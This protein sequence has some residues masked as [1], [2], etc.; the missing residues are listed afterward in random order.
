M[1]EK[2]LFKEWNQIN[3]SPISQINHQ[4]IALS[5]INN[6]DEE[7]NI[8]KWE[9]YISK[10]TKQDNPYYY[11]GKWHLYIEIP[12]NYPMNPPS[13]RFDNQTPI[14]HP[15]I[16]FETGEICLDILKAENWSPA[17]NLQYLIVAILMLI[18]HPEPDSPLNID[19][20]NLYRHDKLA[21]ESI[22]QYNIWQYNTFYHHFKNESGIKS[23][24]EV[25]EEEEED[26]DDISLIKDN[27]NNTIITGGYSDTYTKNTTKIKKKLQE[28]L[29]DPFYNDPEIIN[30]SSQK[31]K[32]NLK[33]NVSPN[34]KVIHDVGEEVTKQFIAKVNEIGHMHHHHDDDLF[35]K[36]SHSSVDY[37]SGNDDDLDSVRQQVTQNVTK[38]VEKLCLKST[39]PEI[40]LEDD[41]DDEKF[42]N[43]PINECKSDD[44][45]ENVEKIKQQFLKQVDDKVNEVRKKQEEYQR[46]MSLGGSPN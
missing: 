34:F 26:D 18:D 9:A 16:N 2:R 36:S 25:R 10:P 38:Q 37:S 32:K 41:D 15:N 33:S 7:M 8:M 4:I 43:Q 29:K 42:I 14:N 6:N 27:L 23:E 13:I 39:L 30:K 35:Q 21:F 20:A 46:K 31:K 24:E 11:N 17:W 45:D 28:S 12:L 44:N 22:V 5:P 3:K 40:L 19:S 1:A